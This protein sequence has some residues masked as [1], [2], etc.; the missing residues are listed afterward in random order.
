M[1]QAFTAFTA[2]FARRTFYRPRPAIVAGGHIKE[3]GNV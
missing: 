3:G 2:G 1:E